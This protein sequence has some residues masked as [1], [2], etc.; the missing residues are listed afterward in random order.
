MQ[1]AD[2]ATIDAAI[3]EANEV[4]AGVDASSIPPREEDPSFI[5]AFYYHAKGQALS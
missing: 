3:Q 1:A 2:D 4:I 5:S